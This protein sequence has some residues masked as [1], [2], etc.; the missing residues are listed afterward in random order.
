MSYGIG[1]SAW[2]DVNEAD[3]EVY[4]DS[5][6]KCT[7]KWMEYSIIPYGTT[8]EVL[9]NIITRFLTMSVCGMIVR[10]EVLG[11]AK[12]YIIIIIERYVITW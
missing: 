12:Y 7:R 2:E 6:V 5:V 8:D 10:L 9:S 11:Y 4:R 1:G 3:G